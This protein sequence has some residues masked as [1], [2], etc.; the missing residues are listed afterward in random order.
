MSNNTTKI[1][2]LVLYVNSP[3]S[4]PQITLSNSLER[5]P[6]QD[7]HLILTY[8]AWQTYLSPSIF[9]AVFPFCWFVWLHS[10]INKFKKREIEPCCIQKTEV[11]VTKTNRTDFVKQQQ[12]NTS[13]AHLKLFLFSFTVANFNIC[14]LGYIDLYRLSKWL[15]DHV[16]SVI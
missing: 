2:F 14:I 10:T 5:N 8:S 3:L 13:K 16:P 12:D 11:S 6:Q 7:F 9:Y 15:S 1:L 4:V